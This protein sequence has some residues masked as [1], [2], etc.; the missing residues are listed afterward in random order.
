MHNQEM[1]LKTALR[2]IP[3]RREGGGHGPRESLTETPTLRTFS[4]SQILVVRKK[5][6]HLAKETVSQASRVRHQ[7]R[8]HGPSAR[9]G[10]RG[11]VVKVLTGGDKRK[12]GTVASSRS[13]V[14]CQGGLR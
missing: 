7:S 13:R 4:A 11:R 6:E 14:A 9:T 5:K 12:G 10:K 1:A 8:K 2:S 3:L